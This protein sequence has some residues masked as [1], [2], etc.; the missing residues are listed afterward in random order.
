MPY[1]KRFP[2][3]TDPKKSLEYILNEDKTKYELEDGYKKNMSRELTYIT[4]ENKTWRR[5]EVFGTNGNERRLC[6]GI[7]CDWR[8]ANEEFYLL[9]NRYGN[10]E[11]HVQAY[12]T[13]QSFSW[14]DN[15]SP[16]QVHAMGIQL[17]KELYGDFQCVVTTHCD[18][19]HLHN[20]IIC[21]ATNLHGKKMRD[22][23]YTS[24]QSLM[25]IRE[26]SDR[27][28]ERYGCKIIKDA[29]LIGSNNKKQAYMEH[30]NKT[31]TE[32]IQKDIDK[33]K[34]IA[35]S[36]DEVLRLL[37]IQGYEIKKGKYIS[38]RAFGMERYRRLDSLGKGYSVQE[39]K[40]YF[41]HKNVNYITQEELDKYINENYSDLG[42][43]LMEIREENK[44]SILKSQEALSPTREYPKYKSVR[45][46][47]LDE[48]KR[49]NEEIKLM[50]QF[51][52]YSFNDLND[53]IRQ[54][55]YE[56]ES[57]EREYKK[58]INKLQENNSQFEMY[59]TYLKFYNIYQ[60][61]S[62]ESIPKSERKLSDSSLLWLQ[63]YEE[64]GKPSLS[65]VRDKYLEHKK[66][67]AELS[68][69]IAKFS[70]N[71]YE[72]DKLLQ[73]RNESLEN[74]NRFIKSFEFSEKMIVESPHDE[75]IKK[76]KEGYEYVRLPYT[77]YYTYLVKESIAKNQYGRYQYYVVPDDEYIL[78]DEKGNEVRSI[79][80]NDMAE[81]I[82]ET[83]NNLS[84]LYHNESSEA[85]K[86]RK[87][88]VFTVDIKM[89]DE[90]HETSNAYRIRLPYQK[91]YIEVPKENTVWIKD[92]KTCQVVL[93]KDSKVSMYN[94][95]KEYIGLQK[96]NDLEKNFEEKKKEFKDRNA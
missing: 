94:E 11:D 83:K 54:L 86:N 59:K 64:L 67:E 61:E 90:E 24:P 66:L 87:N 93:N 29:P 13:I 80:A 5:E 85:N 47:A 62:D 1:T 48:I 31:W 63:I 79:E 8:T 71:N 26:V 68:S 21:N 16:E 10:D 41:A 74:S 45:Q 96:V 7:N 37:S 65:E 30:L 27:I 25:K 46:K 51:Q 28:A 18:R 23:F 78:Y 42:K 15:I 73:I 77:N 57:K 58:K 38:V 6:T 22:N 50:D 72:L 32:Q 39:L 20:H 88:F 60:T 35:T 14:E 34:N 3:R 55:Q 36:F 76:E 91:E 44:T 4:N 17:A 49:L 92:G 40:T 19:G 2:I 12:H 89:F 75:K 33:I 43:E 69:E 52:I 9:S 84:D 95:K 82:N 70:Y 56:K 53:R 81:L